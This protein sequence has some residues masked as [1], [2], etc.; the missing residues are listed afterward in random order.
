MDG[1][2]EKEIFQFCSERVKV[3]DHASRLGAS[4]TRQ[5]RSSRTLV[6]SVQCCPR[7]GWTRGSGR[8]G[9]GR[10]TICRI[11]AGRV[12]SALRIFNFFY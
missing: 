4:S 6:E 7:V 11:M 8:D 10:V 9:L 5:T 12:G 2:C 1:P 3:L